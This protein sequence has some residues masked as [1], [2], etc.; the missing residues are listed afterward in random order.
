M[1]TGKEKGRAGCLQAETKGWPWGGGA[2]LQQGLWDGS[3]GQVDMEIGR[4]REVYDALKTLRKSVR[5]Q[6]TLASA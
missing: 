2:E 3:P 6:E 1:S 5:P 4:V